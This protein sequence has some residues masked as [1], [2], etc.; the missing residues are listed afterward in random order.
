MKIPYFKI[1]KKLQE[2]IQNDPDTSNSKVEIEVSKS[3]I[4]EKRSGVIIYLQNA[5]RDPI[6]TGANPNEV[7]I[8]FK[9]ECTSFN[10][11]SIEKAC[12]KRDDLIG[13]VETVIQKPSTLLTLAGVPGV[14]VLTIIQITNTEFETA[15]DENDGFLMSG[16]LTLTIT[17]RG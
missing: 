10:M 17:V 16:I 9:I 8:E 12:E 15:E 1:Q 3:D 14:N 2:I 5:P 13:D 6:V 4:Y 7:V 11:F